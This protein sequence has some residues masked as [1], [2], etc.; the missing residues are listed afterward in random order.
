VASRNE[1]VGRKS[2]AELKVRRHEARCHVGKKELKEQLMTRWAQD[3]KALA[4]RR[5]KRGLFRYL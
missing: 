5:R 4:R 3:T 2:A 1:R